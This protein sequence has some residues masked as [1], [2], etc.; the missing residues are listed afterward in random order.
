MPFISPSQNDLAKAYQIV[1]NGTSLLYNEREILT[2][3]AQASQMNVIATEIP[4]VL[5]I[6]PKL[7]GDQRGFFLETYQFRP[8]RRARHRAAV[9]PG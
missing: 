9:R 5:I 1:C 6:E 7:F 2:D 8:L 3:R 4:E